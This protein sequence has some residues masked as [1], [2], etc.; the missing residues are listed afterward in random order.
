MDH[1]SITNDLTALFQD[2]ALNGVTNDN[3]DIIANLFMIILDDNNFTIFNNPLIA[4]LIYLIEMN[5]SSILIKHLVTEF[6]LKSLRLI[7][8]NKNSLM[9]EDCAAPSSQKQCCTENEEDL[10]LFTNL[11]D[12]PPEGS[13]SRAKKIEEINGKKI[14]KTYRINHRGQAVELLGVEEQDFNKELEQLNDSV[15]ERVLKGVTNAKKTPL[16]EDDL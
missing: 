6:K 4:N 11:I 3:V 15:I 8:T 10:P 14:I 13:F 9:Q 7:Y 16:T 2:V 12:L 5:E 1:N